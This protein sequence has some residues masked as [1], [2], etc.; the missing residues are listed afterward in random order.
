[1]SRDALERLVIAA[2][3]LPQ[4]PDGE[5]DRGEAMST[6]RGSDRR[7]SLARGGLRMAPAELRVR[8]HELLAELAR[9]IDAALPDTLA[10]ADRAW[11]QVD[12]LRIR[13]AAVEREARALLQAARSFL[14]ADEAAT[15]A[16]GLEAQ[17]TLDAALDL[18]ALLERRLATLVRLQLR[19]ADVD[20]DAALLPEGRPFLDLG[21]ALHETARRWA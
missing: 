9:R 13:D 15:R 6:P 5:G 8:V 10:C 1:V 20:R 19:A 12:A 16:L 18:V 4:P 2:R 7:G 17:L 3:A 21:A 11:D 14:G